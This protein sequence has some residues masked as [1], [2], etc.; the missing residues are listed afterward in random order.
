MGI[1]LRE[2]AGKRKRFIDRYRRLQCPTRRPARARGPVDLPARTHHLLQGEPRRP[3][4]ASDMVRLAVEP[5]TRMCPWKQRGSADGQSC[6]MITSWDGKWG[7]TS[8]PT[9]ASS[10]SSI[11]TIPRTAGARGGGA[12]SSPAWVLGARRTWQPRTRPSSATA[13]AGPR[14]TCGWC[15]ARTRGHT[16]PTRSTTS[17]RPASSWSSL[18]S[19]TG[20]HCCLLISIASGSIGRSRHWSP[21]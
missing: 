15:G 11:R 14:G 19:R 3:G 20:S 7:S 8:P 2:D 16:G 5:L 6:N 1:R 9:R 12:A 18:R 10:T 13:R 21:S 4:T 17:T